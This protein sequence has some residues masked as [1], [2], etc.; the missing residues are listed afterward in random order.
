MN[1]EK[2]SLWQR[3]YRKVLPKLYYRKVIRNGSYVDK[4]EIFFKQFVKKGKNY[5]KRTSA[6]KFRQKR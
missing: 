4:N 2:K 5:G 6:D 1:N 3:L